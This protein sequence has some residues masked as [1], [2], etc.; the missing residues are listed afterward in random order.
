MLTSAYQFWKD[1]STPH[2]HPLWAH[3]VPH[4]RDLT[5]SELATL[6]P[7]HS[8]SYGWFY[9]TVIT[10][11]RAYMSWLVDNIGQLGG[12]FHQQ[13]IVHPIEELSE[14]EVIVNCTGLGARNLSFTSASSKDN[15]V[16][17]GDVMP[18][19]GQVVRVRAP[20]IQHYYNSNGEA[21]IIPNLDSVVLGGTVGPGD[22]DLAVREDE[23]RGIL[24]RCCAIVPSLRNAEVIGGW[25]GLR[26]GRV[27]GMRLEKEE[28]YTEGGRRVVV[29]HNYG[30]GGSG[31]TLAWG[32]AGEVVEMLC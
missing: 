3:I 18:V 12:K 22:W 13:K 9:T 7:S 6:D 26:P 31:Y 4:F 20:W 5:P 29:V 32:C 11:A 8:H 1:T 25:T 15:Y 27:S 2:P 14:Y 19:R 16:A 24:E 10:D 17:D 28:V 21:Y 30:A 23:E